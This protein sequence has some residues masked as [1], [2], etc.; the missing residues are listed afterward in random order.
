MFDFANQGYTLLIT[1]VIFPVLFTT[2]I[3]GD[4]ENEY[5][6]GNLLW[7]VALAI[8][9]MMV[10]LTG[11][12]FGAI[13]DFSASKKKFLFASYLFTVVTTALLYFVAPGYIMLGVVLMVLSNFGYAVGENFI[14]AFLTDLGPPQDLGK[15]SAFGWSMGYVGG[16]VSTGFV[17]AF[18]GDPTLENFARI[19]WVGPFTAIFFLVTAIPTFLWVKE[20]G[21][22]RVL[23]AGESYARVG[24]RR[25]R[26]T[27]R[28]IG[29]FR[30]LAVLL[31]SIFFS[32]AAIYIII[33]FAFI[34]G[35]QVI[36][37][38]PGVQ[39]YMFVIVQ[40][41]AALGAVAFGFI[42]DRIGA[43]QTY[44]STMVLWTVGIVL[45]YATP[46]LTAFLNAALGRDWH[47]QYVFL[48]VGVVTGV[49]LG[50]SQ[51]AGRAMVGV[52]SPDGK[53]SEFFGFWGLSGKLAGVFGVIG[54][55][56][57]QNWFGL[58]VAILF[59]AVLFIVSILVA[60][61]VNQE[62]GRRAVIEYSAHNP[63]D[64]D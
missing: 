36:R 44:I 60:L 33:T 61:F 16:L 54:L 42:Q 34:Y 9:Y 8:S 13:M 1:T 28:E 18:L 25:L 49:S 63:A 50:S 52:F 26:A 23:Q 12:I 15:I 62:R 35:E 37:W 55:G 22:A 48:F 2:V 40:I 24:F 21:V 20:R 6:L 3:V 7:S 11:P 19:R 59:C 51:S 27:M 17:I 58:Q 5:R 38:D 4:A 30:D 56:I 39:V 47:P 31:L 45:I 29:Q 46:Q 14:A 41:T 32:M 53:S 10:V 64:A 57:L 43:K